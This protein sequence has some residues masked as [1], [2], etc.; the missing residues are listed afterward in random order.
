MIVVAHVHLTSPLIVL[1]LPDKAYQAKWDLANETRD[2]DQAAARAIEIVATKAPGAFVT[3]YH[4]T[5]CGQ[6]E[7]ALDRRAPFACLSERADAFSYWTR[8]EDW[9]GR[10]A[11]FVNDW[12]YQRPVDHILKCDRVEELPSLETMRGGKKARE[13]RY[14]LCHGFRGRVT[15]IAPLGRKG[16]TAREGR[17]LR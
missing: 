14:A 6:L 16:S 13:F 1:L 12:R 4:Y 17:T 3:S 7:F 9:V 2:W 15:P 5:L 11:I 8:D 10:N